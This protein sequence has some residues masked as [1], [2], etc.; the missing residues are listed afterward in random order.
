MYENHEVIDRLE[1]PFVWTFSAI[2]MYVAAALLLN[3]WFI[4]LGW[5]WDA[6]FDPNLSFAD[7]YVADLK[8]GLAEAERIM[9]SGK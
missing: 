3:E 5:F 7:S 1:M 2:A 9:N 4:P 6:M 8:R